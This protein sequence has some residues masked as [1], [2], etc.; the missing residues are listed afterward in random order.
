MVNTQ[1]TQTPI[2]TNTIIE[3]NILSS[4]ATIFINF[5]HRITSCCNRNREDHND[6]LD[7]TETSYSSDTTKISD[8]SNEEQT[9]NSGLIS[10]FFSGLRNITHRVTSFFNF[11]RINDESDLDDY[12][13][14]FNYPANIN[15]DTSEEN[16]PDELSY[17]SSFSIKEEYG[18]SIETSPEPLQNQTS[19]IHSNEINLNSVD[20]YAKIHNNTN[21]NQVNHFNDDVYPIGPYVN[22]SSPNILQAILEEIDEENSDITKDSNNSTIDKDENDNSSETNNLSKNEKK[23]TFILSSNSVSS[24]GSEITVNLDSDQELDQVDLFTELSEIYNSILT[25]ISEIETINQGTGSFNSQ[26][27]G[28]LRTHS[29]SALEIINSINNI[30]IRRFFIIN[31][32]RY[33]E[34]SRTG[35][36]SNDQEITQVDLTEELERNY[37][38]ILNIFSEIE[39]ISQESKSELGDYFMQQLNTL[40]ANNKLDLGVDIPTIRKS[41]S[42][43]KLIEK[44]DYLKLFKK[45]K[46]EEE[47]EEEEY[48]EDK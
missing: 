34:L 1:A 36:S 45:T 7:I 24:F 13:N 10:R 17:Q 15:I 26:R 8:S 39:S 33:N 20:F 2:T 35:S 9:T 23:V 27:F 22:N 16:N 43:R 18:S 21:T 3:R 38:L 41:K 25:I 19:N 30:S 48:N 42:F 11:N 44:N 47:E 40:S 46:T 4:I 29:N 6:P 12:S 37:G 5:Y 28:T 32:N 31:R 14:S